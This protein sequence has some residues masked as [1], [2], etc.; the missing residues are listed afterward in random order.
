MYASTFAVQITS[1]KWVFE[2]S[3]A[4]QHSIRVSYFMM[5]DR[6]APFELELGTVVVVR[7]ALET[8]EGKVA[9]RA[10]HDGMARDTLSMDA[11]VLSKQ[12]HRERWSPKPLL[13]RWSF[14]NFDELIQRP[15]HSRADVLG[16]VVSL[17]TPEHFEYKERQ[18]QRRTLELS[19]GL[20][21]CVRVNV[22]L[23]GDNPLNLELGTVIGLRGAKVR[24]L[25]GIMSLSVSSRAVALDVHGAKATALRATVAEA[26]TSLEGWEEPQL[27]SPTS[28]FRGGGFDILDSNLGSTPAASGGED[29]ESDQRFLPS[30]ART[31][32][33]GVVNQLEPPHL[34]RQCAFRSSAANHSFGA[35][36][37]VLDF[38]TPDAHDSSFKED[39]ND[40]SARANGQHGSDLDDGC[41]CPTLRGGGFG[42]DAPVARRCLLPGFN[43]ASPYANEA[44]P[45]GAS[46]EDASRMDVS[47]E[48]A[49]GDANKPVDGD[50]NDASVQAA[51]AT[52]GTGV[53]LLL[54]NVKGGWSQVLACAEKDA[55]THYLTPDSSGYVPYRHDRLLLTKYRDP[56]QARSLCDSLCEALDVATGKQLGMFG[57]EKLKAFMTSYVPSPIRCSPMFVLD[58][59][60]RCAASPFRLQL[61]PNANGAK[62]CTWTALLALTEGIYLVLVSKKHGS[63]HVG[64]FVVYDAWRNLLIIDP[65]CSMVVRV[66]PEYI[67][68]QCVNTFLSVHY[69]LM[70]PLRVCKLMVAADRV[71]ETKFNTPTHYPVLDERCSSKHARACTK[72]KWVATL[73]ACRGG[74]ANA[75]D[76]TANQIDDEGRSPWYRLRPPPKE[77]VVYI[78]RQAFCVRHPRR[79]QRVASAVGSAVVVRESTLNPNAKPFVPVAGGAR[80]LNESHVPSAP[81]AVCTSEESADGETMSAYELFRLGNIQRNEAMLRHL[82][83]SKGSPRV[84]PACAKKI[85]RR[86]KIKINAAS[87]R[88]SLRFV[89]R[90]APRYKSTR[91]YKRKDG[92]TPLPAAVRVLQDRQGTRRAPR[93]HPWP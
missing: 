28:T 69:S 62:T 31:P 10:F 13:P 15:D 66:A 27:L 77:H 45:P 68:E 61:V 87:S 65:G 18:G 41:A 36:A 14:T 34:E 57:T 35:T 11:D 38:D 73:P 67:E 33:F 16:Y 25:E 60:F 53:G 75:L 64:H 5:R 48:P 7:G 6:E 71:S 46:D 74:G 43:A 21:R 90:P 82:G 80:T 88:R 40:L 92:R 55:S 81:P 30:F 85:R 76:V 32:M 12:W 79:A 54:L 70:A 2:L 8:C 24:Q 83:L 17:G 44:S 47:I 51:L 78:E 56:H 29:E 9:L 23:N 19:D 84:V 1:S 22:Y 72:R 37:L 93:M 49:A 63:T 86:P 52:D 89:G 3:D 20:D 26:R 91:P 58:Q 42:L 39:G 50:V 59:Y 4:S